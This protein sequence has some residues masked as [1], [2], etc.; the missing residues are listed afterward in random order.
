M[1]EL[2]IAVQIVKKKEKKRKANNIARGPY[3]NNIDKAA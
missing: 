3:C 1:A 2:L